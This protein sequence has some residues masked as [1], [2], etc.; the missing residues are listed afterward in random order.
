M[1]A[2]VAYS[3]NLTHFLS[4]RDSGKT[5]RHFDNFVRRWL[6]RDIP[7]LMNQSERAKSAMHLFG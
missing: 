5:S 7:C 6:F 4:L 2:G 1:I 3:F